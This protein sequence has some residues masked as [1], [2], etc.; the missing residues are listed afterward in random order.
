ML[1]VGPLARSKEPLTREALN[2]D[3][4]YY[5]WCGGRAERRVNIK[6]LLRIK[7]IFS[8]A[9]VRPS[10]CFMTAE[11]GNREWRDE[12]FAALH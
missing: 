9:L 12:A 8:S 11:N 1:S 4:D 10:D 5:Y 2:D 6:K 3:N 7:S